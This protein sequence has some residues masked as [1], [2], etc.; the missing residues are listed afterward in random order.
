M[1]VQDWKAPQGQLISAASEWPGLLG[2]IWRRRAH[3]LPLKVPRQRIGKSFSLPSHVLAKTAPQTLRFPASLQ[4]ETQVKNSSW[5]D[6][7]CSQDPGSLHLSVYVTVRGVT[8]MR[9]SVPIIT[10]ITFPVR[11]VCMATYSCS[12]LERNRHWSS[13]GPSPQATH[14]C[15]Q[16]TYGHKVPV[17]TALADLPNAPLALSGKPALVNGHTRSNVSGFVNQLGHVLALSYIHDALHC[18]RVLVMGT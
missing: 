3:P 7:L 17:F 16:E 18:G 11:Q 10:G 6:S 8:V 5:V 14:A 12:A 15:S 13:H 4:D 1:D 9:R 2:H